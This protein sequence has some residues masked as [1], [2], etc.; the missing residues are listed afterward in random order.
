M[1]YKIDLQR[2]FEEK[3]FSLKELGYININSWTESIVDNSYS[4]ENELF[5][6]KAK[7]NGMSTKQ[8]AETLNRSYLG[9]VDKLRRM[10]KAE[11][12]R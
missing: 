2:R 11:N 9:V 6:L 1:I 7:E 10:K 4:K 12:S 3:R 5:I 8:I